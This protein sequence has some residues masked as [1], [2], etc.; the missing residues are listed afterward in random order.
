MPQ[1]KYTLTQAEY[2]AL[3]KEH[4][5]LIHVETPPVIAD[6]NLA[7]S[8]GDLSENADYDAAR[9]HQARVAA[10]ISE[11][12]NILHNSVITATATGN[13]AGI[14]STV[15]FQDLLRNREEVVRVMG[16]TGANPFGE[17]VSVSNESP[18]GKAIIGSSVGDTVVVSTDNGSYEIKILEIHKGDKVEKNSKKAA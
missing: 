3:E 17:V 5:Y 13:E 18:L 8:Q 9:D 15:R 6:L 12:E 10:R 7:R 11:I 16:N 2:D 4:E 14:G 1:K